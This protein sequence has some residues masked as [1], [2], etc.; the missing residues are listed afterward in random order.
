MLII[1]NESGKPKPVYTLSKGGQ[2]QRIE[3][4][5]QIVV[6]EDQV[7]ESI[8]NKITGQLNQAPPAPV[9]HLIT[10]LMNKFNMQGAAT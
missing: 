8:R 10:E 6:D 9:A 7:P 3:N 2:W 1:E 5:E 4:G